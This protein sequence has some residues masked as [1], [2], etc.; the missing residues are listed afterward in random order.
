MA[1]RLFRC[2]ARP[3]RTRFRPSALAGVSGRPT[4]TAGRFSL[5][6]T[7]PAAGADSDGWSSPYTEPQYQRCGLA[8]AGLA[9][10][11]SEQP[12]LEWHTLGGHFPDSEAF[13]LAV[14]AGVAGGYQRR[15]MCPHR[16]N[17]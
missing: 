11:R 17:G 12:G 10:L 16:G 7:R 1:G 4:S 15:E 6:T 3:G 9:A 5:S 13:W 8:S 14:G 2:W